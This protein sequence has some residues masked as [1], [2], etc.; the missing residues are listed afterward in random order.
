MSQTTILMLM[1]TVQTAYTTPVWWGTQ[2]RREEGAALAVFYFAKVTAD[3][4]NTGY[5]VRIELVVQGT[6]SPRLTR[7]GQAVDPTLRGV[8]K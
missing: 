3:Y 7:S 1:C 2:R 8:G 4:A 5:P 6:V